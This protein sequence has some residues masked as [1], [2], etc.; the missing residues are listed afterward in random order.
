MTKLFLASL[1]VLAGC[2]LPPVTVDI[3]DSQVKV[4]QKMTTKDAEVKVEADKSC[5][6]YG[7]KAVYISTF[8]KDFDKV[9]LFAC[10]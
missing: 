3:S 4:L 1:V 10:K 6:I 9:H 8:T 5:G 2:A 7:K